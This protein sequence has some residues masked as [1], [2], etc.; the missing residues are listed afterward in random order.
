MISR[1]E[2]GI[3]APAFTT[4]ELL[5]EALGVPEAS[6]F[7]TAMQMPPTGERGLI[8]QRIN[9]ITSKMNDRDLSRAAAMLD[10]MRK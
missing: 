9:F 8:L 6:F 4:I 7:G 2:R 1:M 3:T 10:A 5:A